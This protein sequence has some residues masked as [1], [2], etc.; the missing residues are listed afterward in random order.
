MHLTVRNPNGSITSIDLHLIPTWELGLESRPAKWHGL[1]GA[2]LAVVISA[3]VNGML[4]RVVLDILDTRSR[5]DEVPVLVDLGL[6]AGARSADK[7]RFAEALKVLHN[8]GMAAKEIDEVIANSAALVDCFWNFRDGVWSNNGTGDGAAV[9]HTNAV[10][11]YSWVL[12][13][14]RYGV[15]LPEP[16]IVAEPEE[17]AKVD[18]PERKA[19]PPRVSKKPKS[20]PDPLLD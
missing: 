14:A 3:P 1:E 10:S 17:P 5:G 11:K 7:A 2:G 13:S 8:S 19:F 18:K 20:E 16:V 12:S 4:V 15:A 6:P 9:T